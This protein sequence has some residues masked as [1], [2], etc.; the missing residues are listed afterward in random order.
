MINEWMNEYIFGYNFEFLVGIRNYGF[1]VLLILRVMFFFLIGFSYKEGRW[2]WE[3]VR[4]GVVWKERGLGNFK[5]RE[6]NRWR[7]RKRE[8]LVYRVLDDE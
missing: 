6:K 4:V 7:R 5:W 3:W 8:V 2:L 1:L